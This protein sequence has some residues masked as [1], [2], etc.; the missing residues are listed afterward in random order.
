MSIPLSCLLL[1]H[2]K[3]WRLPASTLLSGKQPEPSLIRWPKAELGRTP[4]PFHASQL[5]QISVLDAFSPATYAHLLIQWNKRTM[6]H[7]SPSSL[8]P[9]LQTRRASR[10]SRRFTC[11]CAHS[12]AVDFGVPGRSDLSKGASDLREDARVAHESL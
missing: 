1:L 8:E 10:L 9:L 12:E 4:R 5:L 2:N 3:L 11:P 6:R 7:V